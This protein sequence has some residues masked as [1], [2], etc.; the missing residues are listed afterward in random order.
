[1]NAALDRALGRVWQ[2]PLPGR[3]LDDLVALDRVAGHDG[4]RRAADRILDHLDRAGAVDTRR[5]AV[6][7]EVWHADGASL[8]ID[9]PAASAGIDAQGDATPDHYAAT[10]LPYSP[11]GTVIGPVRSIDADADLDGA[12]ALS[13]AGGD[14]HRLAAVGRAA[15]RGAAGFL[16]AGDRPGQLRPTGT[17]GTG[18]A[19]PLVAAG[20]SHETAATL[21]RRDRPVELSVSARLT[22]GETHLVRGRIGPDTA[23]RVL[24]VAHHDAH[25][26]GEGALDN[27]AGVA[28]LVAVVETLVGVDLPLGVDVATVGGEEVGLLGSAALAAAM[29]TDRI[30]AVV[31]CDGIGRH[32]RPKAITHGS[33][34]L[35][36]LIAGVAR[37][38]DR[39]ID[40]VTRTHPYS[41]HWPFLRRGV[42]ALQFHSTRPGG[43]TDRWERGVTHTAADT[44]EKVSIATVRDHAMVAA[45]AVRR[46]LD[47]RVPRRDPDAI[48]AGFEE[49]GL[50]DRMRTAGVWPEAW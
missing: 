39:P 25:A 34:A 44:R 17:V 10:A 8:A 43:R 12:I 41:D 9:P 3:V 28:A 31:N 21:D 27:G 4:E 49:T 19:G 42:P 47:T 46:L 6:P 29:D 35:D 14:T 40:R 18:Q 24:V 32:P 15:E 50:S 11:A 48:R 2:S 16:L 30:R 23:D 26:I 22:D 5:E 45:V 1:M 7:I 38:L 36:D 33:D 13:R 37:D 20:I